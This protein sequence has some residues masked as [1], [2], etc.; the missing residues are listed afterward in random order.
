SSG[1]FFVMLYWQLAPV[2]SAGFG[3]SL[4][5]HKLLAYPIPHRKL[6]SIEV[7]LRLTTCPEMLIVVSGA[8]IGLL[9]NPLYK[10]ADAVFIVTGALLFASTN[11]LLSAGTRHLTERLFRRSRMK[12]VLMVVLATVGLL[13]QIL[14]FMNMRSAALFRLAPVRI[15]WP[16][17]AVAHLFLRERTVSAAAVAVV[18]LGIA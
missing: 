18:Y 1:L 11:I 5:L 7:M 13:P 9:R 8:A 3:A 4:D 2:L 14:I 15:V 6:F 16:W 17:A 12:E 10:S